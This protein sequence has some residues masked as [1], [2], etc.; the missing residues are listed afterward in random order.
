M[1]LKNITMTKPISKLVLY[2]L[3]AFLATS[4]GHASLSRQLKSFSKETIVIPDELT[5]VRGHNVSRISDTRKEFTFVTYFDSLSCSRCQIAHLSDYTDLYEVADSVGVLDFLVVFSP[6]DEEYDEVVKELV[7]N[8]FPYPVYVDYGGYFRKANASI[9][10]DSRFHSFLLDRDGHP[11]FV[12][13]PVASQKLW[14]LFEKAL[15]RL[16]HVNE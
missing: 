15:D 12:G 4:C 9:P 5:E 11:A 16:V 3:L 6:R 1:S 13:N 10:E 14:D 2:L 7:L 8:D